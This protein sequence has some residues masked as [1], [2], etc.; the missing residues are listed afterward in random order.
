MSRRVKMRTMIVFVQILNLREMTTRT[1]TANN[2]MLN[3]LTN[4]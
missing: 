4:Y 3:L 2:L 1:K